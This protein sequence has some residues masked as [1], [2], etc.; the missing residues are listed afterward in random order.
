MK[1]SIYWA[2]ALV[3]S[4]VGGG[5]IAFNSTR[6]GDER[7]ELLAQPQVE[8]IEVIEATP[9]TLLA[10]KTH[11]WR[12]EAPAYTSGTLLVL[13]TSPENLIPRQTYEH[14][15]YVGDE[16]AERVNVGERSGYV[17]AIVPGDVDL[18]STPIFFGTPALPEQVTRAAA[19]IELAKATNLGVRGM[20]AARA[21]AVTGE[22]IV[23]QDAYELYLQA[24][25]AI[26]RFA[27]DE[28]DLVTGLR[29]TRI[30]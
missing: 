2:A 5:V 10:P 16:T 19:E 29:A 3:L 20:G 14:V 4:A 1:H 28:V 21:A 9:F 27:P 26:E 15:L 17:I 25:V 24:S 18:A 8:A 30:R 11:T 12:A 13:R 23:L 7:P 6:A 22:R